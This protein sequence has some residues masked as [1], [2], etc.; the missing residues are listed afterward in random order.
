MTRF[1]SL[2]IILLLLLFSFCFFSSQKRR[3]T[4]LKESEKETCYWSLRGPLLNGYILALYSKALFFKRRNGTFLL[5][6][7]P[8]SGCYGP[9]RGRRNVWELDKIMPYETRAEF[10]QIFHSFFGQ[11]SFKKKWF[12]D[13]LTFK[14]IFEF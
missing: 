12:W 11:W 1:N 7:R 14:R 10:C 8:K 2:D 3:N 4:T 9:D 6:V 5:H 13:I